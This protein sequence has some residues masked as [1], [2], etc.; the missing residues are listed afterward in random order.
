M[1][2]VDVE[3]F[4]STEVKVWP[5]GVLAGWAGAPGACVLLGLPLAGTVT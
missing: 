2:T 1:T 3:P 5:S 4:G